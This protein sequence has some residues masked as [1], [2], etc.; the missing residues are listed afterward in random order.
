M[1]GLYLPLLGFTPLDYNTTDGTIVYIA[2]I[3]QGSESK[4]EVPKHGIEHKVEDRRESVKAKKSISTQ[5]LIYRP[6]S[7]VLLTC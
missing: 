2:G 1:T 4:Q 5:S 3:G 6:R 7:A